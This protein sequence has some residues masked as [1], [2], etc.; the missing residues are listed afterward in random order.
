[1]PDLADKAAQAVAQRQERQGE[2]AP[3]PSLQ[4]QINAP[5]VRDEI[6]KQLG[7]KYD[8]GV[9]IR[10]VVNSIKAAPQ[11][12]KCDPASVF[13]GMFTAAQLR[14]ELGS[15][16]GQA[17]L[18]PRQSWKDRENPYEGWSASFQIG[19]KG[20]L[21]LAYRTGVITGATAE[22]V[23][24]G[25]TFKRASNSERGPFYDLDYGPEHDEPDTQIMGVLGMF[26]VRG[27]DRPQWKYLTIDQVEARRPDH[28][29]EQTVRSGSRAGETYVPNT[30]WKTDYR[31]MVEKT[32]LINGLRFAPRSAQLA[33]AMEVD[34]H[35]LTATRERPRE[36]EARRADRDDE[37]TKTLDLD[38]E[39]DGGAEGS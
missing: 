7:P 26:W 18:I 23:M 25:D 20:A 11:L 14:L 10:S 4:A 29:K 19:Y 5:W 38:T 17:F 33:L 24:V 22:L 16:L 31:A 8:A 3:L 12:A 21:A 35:V 36:L 9:F 6:Q 1:M 30:P 39:T 15:A 32:G 13:G 27:A 34:D 28:T 2:E 37:Q